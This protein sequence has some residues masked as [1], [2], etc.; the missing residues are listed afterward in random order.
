MSVNLQNSRKILNVKP[1]SIEMG[2]HRL[3]MVARTIRHYIYVS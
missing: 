2:T 1:V 3:Y